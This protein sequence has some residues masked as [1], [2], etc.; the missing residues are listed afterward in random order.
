MESGV[1]PEF[2]RNDLLLIGTDTKL[3]ILTLEF[4]RLRIFSIDQKL[5]NLFVSFC[6]YFGK[7]PLTQ[8][9][10]FCNHE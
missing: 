5:M 4:I 8:K 9:V 1:V 3:P 2:I 10:K 6:S 7:H